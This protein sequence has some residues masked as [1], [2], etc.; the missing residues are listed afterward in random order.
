MSRIYV[1]AVSSNS[2]WPDSFRKEF[3]GQI[4]K[5][6]AILTES[7]H[8]IHGNTVLYV[9]RDDLTDL[10]ACVK[11][12]ELV[13][14]L[15][16]NLIHWTRQI[17]EVIAGSDASHSDAQHEDRG[18]LAEIQHWKSRSDDLS[19]I[20]SQLE[21]SDVKRICSVLEKA[22]SSYLKPFSDLAQEIMDGSEEAR[23]NLKFLQILFDPCT[24]LA[25]AKPKDISQHLPEILNLIRVIWSLSKYYHTPERIM[26]LL[27]KVSNEIILRCCENINLKDIFDGKIEE[28]SQVLQESI[29]SGDDWKEIY[30]KMVE[31]MK[32][33][34]PE[35]AWNYDE[36]RIFAQIDAFMQRCRD[37]LEVCESQNQFSPSEESEIP[38]FSGV[39][40]DEI[41]KNLTKIQQSFKKLIT[42]FSNL[43]YNILDVKATKW[44]DD[45]NV[46]KSGVKDLEMMM[47]NVITS[48]FET[49]STVEQGL[50]M[51]EAFHHMAK[52]EA[53]KRTV[54]NK[55]SFVYSLF[56][57]ELTKVGREFNQNRSSPPI[58]QGIP[59]YSGSAVWAK[60][61]QK[62]LQDQMTVLN[63]TYYLRSCREHEEAQSNFYALSGAIDEYIKKNYQDWASNIDENYASKLER[64]LLVQVAGGFLEMNFDKDLIRLFQEVRYWEKLVFPIPY[65][66]MEMASQREKFR[67]IRENVLLV[68]RDFNKILSITDKGERKLFQEKLN[69]LKRIINPGITKMHWSSRGIVDYY[70]RQCRTHCEEVYR[71]VLTF[72]S[73]HDQIMKL[74]NMIADTLLVKIE[75]KRIYEEGSFE[76]VQDEHR[77][78]VKNKLKNA[79]EEIKNLISKSYEMFSNDMEEIQ[80]EW[81][82]YVSKIDRMVEDALRTTVKKSLQEISKAIN[83]DA[84]TEVHPIFKVNMT[85]ERERVEFKPT[86]NN[87]TQMV[88]NVSK[89]LITV[90]TIIPKLKDLH[91][92]KETFYSRISNDEDILKIMVS[93][94]GGMS[95]SLDKLQ[96]YLTF[97]EKYKHTWDYD[98]DA[99]I[100]RYAKANRTLATFEQDIQRYRELQND[101]LAEDTI[102]NM[103]FICIDCS[104]LK[105]AIVGHCIGWQNKFTSLLHSNATSE[106]NA[107]RDLFF[108]NTQ[109]FQ[110]HPS[111]LDELAE[112][113]SQ[114][115]KLQEETDSISARFEP[116]Y[117][118]YKLLEKFDII[119]PEEEKEQVE[120]LPNEFVK[121]KA[122]LTDSE[123][124]LHSSKEKMKGNL[125]QSLEQ[126]KIDV[127]N[128]RKKFLSEGPFDPN[129]DLQKAFSQ[130]QH[131][132][133]MTSAD[134]EGESKMQ[135]G[136]DLFG[137][138]RPVY[139]DISLVE[140]DLELLE[141]CWNLVKEWNEM[142]ELWKN[143]RFTDLHTEEMEE[144]AAKFNKKLQ[145]IGKEVKN[146]DIWEKTRE[147]VD[148]FKRALPLIQDLRNEA[149]RDRHW[150]QL[151]EHIGK[152][153]EPSD[154]DFTLNKVMELQLPSFAEVIGT[155]SNSASKELMIEKAVNNMESTWNVMKLD[156]HKYK[157]DYLMLRSTE[158]VFAALEDNVVSLST[159]KSSKYALSF[160]PELEKWEKTLSLVSETVESILTVQRY[161]M[162]LENIFVGSEDIRKQLPTESKLFDQINTTWKQI[163]KRLQQ[164]NN[165]VSACKL[166]GMLKTLNN[167]ES[168]LEKI[169]KSLDQYLETKRQAFP[170]FYF[171]SNDDLLEILGQARDPLAVQPHLKKCFEA[172]KSLKLEPPGKDGRRNY[173]AIAMNSPDG[174]SVLFTS[175]IT[176]DGPVEVWLLEIENVMRQTLR[177]VL[178]QTLSS[179]KGTKRE[180]W[181]NDFPGQLLI[182][183]GQMQWTSECEKG[184]LDSE[185]GNKVGVRTAKKKQVV[186]LNKY[187]EMVRGQLNK[188]NRNKVVAIITIEVHARDVIDKMIKNGTAYLNDFEWMSQLR[189]YWDKEIDDCLTKQNQSKFVYGYEYQGNN[190]RLVI[191]PLTD[192]CY[193]TLTT[194]LHLKRGGNPLGPAGTGKT[195]TVKDLGKAIAMYVLVFNCSDGLDYKSLG[196]MF[197]GLCQQGA[198]SCFDE[199]NR[200]DIEVLSVVAQQILQI[201]TAVKEMQNSLIF[202]G[203]HIKL[204]KTLGIFVTMNPGYA[205]RSELPDNLKALL[206]P[207]AMMVPDLALIAEIM[208]S[209]EGFQ[210]GKVL[211]KKLITLYQLMQ[212]QMSKQDHYDYGM[213]AIKAVLV[214][215][216]SVKRV[217]PEMSEEVILLRAVRDMSIPKLVGSDIH[218]FNALCGDLFPGVELPVV[219]YGDLL[220]GIK[221]SLTESKLQHN[222]NIILK[223]IQIYEAKACRH[224]NMLVGRTKTGKTTAWSTL[225][226]AHNSL[227]K[228]NKSGWERVV[229]FVLNPKAFSLG[230]LFGEYNLMTREWTDGTL[231]S[232]MREACSDEKPDNKWI[233]LDG[234]VDTLWIES[235]NTVL[236]DNKLLTLINGERIA[237][238]PMV[239]CLFEVEDLAVASPATV[240]R[241]GMIYFDLSGLGW[242][243]YTDSWL[244]SKKG[245]EEDAEMVPLISNLIDKYIDKILE[246]KKHNVTELIPLSPLNTVISLTKLF[247]ALS[248]KANGIVP[249]SDTL[250]KMTEMWFIYCLA[251]SLGAGADENGRRKLDV[252]IREI[253]AQLP[254]K[255]TV[256]DYFVDVHKVQ[257]SPWEEKVTAKQWRP[258]ADTPFFKLIVPTI[259]SIRNTSLLDVL[260]REHRDVIIT[261]PVGCGK[262]TI[263]QQCLAQL[264][265]SMTDLNIQFSA[266][267]SSNRVQETIEASVEKRTKDT[268]APPAN[269]KM[270]IFIDDM[271]MPQKDTFGSMPPLELLKMWLEYGFWYDRAKQLKRFIKDC[272]VLGALG[273]PGGGRNWLPQRFQSK[274]H[275]VNFTFPD[276][277][278]VRRIF[279][280][281]INMKLQHFADEIKPLGDIM[282]QATIEIYNTVKAELLPTPS[283][284]HYMFN[285]RDLSRVFQGVLRADEQFTDSR[286]AMTRLWIHE[287]FRLFHD[288]LTDDVDRA[289]FRKLMEGKL[290][291][292]FQTSW[293]Q[294][295]IGNGNP[296]M[297]V[298]FLRAGYDPPPYEE[299]MD[300]A[301]FKTFVEEKLDEYNTEPGVVQMNLVLFRDALAHLSRICRVIKLPR[302]NCLL[303]GVG[304]SGR[305]SISRLACYICE[306]KVFMIEISKSYRY[307]DFRED[308]KKLFEMAG[309]K[310][311]PT[312]FLFNDSQIVEEFFLEDINC[313]LGSGEVPGLFAPDEVSNYRELMRNEARAAGME[314][315]PTVLWQLFIERCRQNL[316]LILCMSPIGEAFRTRVRMFPNLVNCCTIDWFPAWSNEAL[317]EVSLKFLN[318]S[319]NQNLKEATQGVSNIFA[320]VH[321]SVIDSTAR[322]LQELKR[323]NYVTPTNFLELVK[324]YLS[325]LTQKQKE[326]EDQI[327]KFR[328]GIEKLDNS[329]EQVE[330]MSQELEVKKKEVSV[331]QKECE[332]MLVVIVR[333]RKI[334]DEQQRS[335]QAESE[336]VQREEAETQKIADDAQKDL[337]EALP[338]LSAAEEA[339]NALNKKDLS[340]I[341]AYAKPPPLVEMV[342]EAV[343][344]L[345]KGQSSWEEAKKELGNP[346]FLS[347][348][349]NYDKDANLNESMLS[350]VSKYTSKP[351]F[352]PEQVGKQSGAAK[353]LC[354][355]VRA[356]V[357]YGRVAKNVAPKKAK[358]KA[359]MDSLV[360]KRS[361][362]KAAQDD[363][364]EVTD[365][366]LALKNKYD[367][368]VGLKERLMNESAELEAKLDRAQRL[369]G[370]LGGERDRWDESATNLESKITKL[371]GDCA[372]SAAYLSYCGPF[373][374]EYR[375]DLVHNSWIPNLKKLE[376]VASDNFSFSE[377]LAEPSTVRTWNIQGLPP[378]SFSTENGVL[379]TLGRRW[380]LCIDPQF[381]ANKWIK[382]LEKSQG[383]KVM[384][385]NMS[386]WMRQM[387]N[388]IQFG[389]P[390]LLQDIGEELD[391]S[392]EPV[393]SKAVTKKGNSMILK[394][395]D[396]EVDFNPD[397]KLYITTKLSNPHYTPEISTKTTVI[398]FAV[399]EDGMEDQVLGLVV[400][401]E[402]PDLEEKNQE[403]IVN[404]AQGK[405][406]L[407]DLENKILALLSSSKGSLLDDASLVDTL[408]TSKLTAEEVSSQLQISEGTKEQIDK[409]RESYRPCATRASILYFVITDLT[410]LDTMYQ[411]SLDYYFDLYNQ[412]ID[413][414]AK[415]EDLEER[416][417]HLNTYHTASAYRNICRSLFEKHKL[418]FSFQMCVKILQKSSKINNDEYQ[419]FLRGPGLV[420]K[421]S[422]PPNPAPEWIA[423]SAW[424]AICEMDN[425]LSNL[426]NITSSLE[427]NTSDWKKWY[428]NQEPESSPLPGE[429]EN[430]CTEL[431]RLVLIRFLRPDRVIFAV[432]SFVAN[433]LGPKFVEPPAFDLDLVYND[434]LPTAPL[435]FVLSPGVDPVVMLK[436]KAEQKGIGDKFYS[437]SLGQGQGPIAGRMLDEGM[438]DGH[439]VFLA[440]CHLCLSYMGEL[441]KRVAELPSRQLHPEF[442][443]WLS[444]APTPKFPMSILQSGLKMT[445]EPPRGIKPN[446]TRLLNKFTEPQFER[447]KKLSKYKKMCFVLCYFHASLLERRKFKNLGW[448]IPYD[449]NDS[450]F[451]ICEDLL[452]LYL[453]NYEQTPWEAI[454][455]LIGE[456]NYGG[457]VTD[458]WDRRLVTTY[459]ESWYSETLF[460]TENFKL[461]SLPTYYIPEDG[462]LQSYKD[463]VAQLPN[464]DAPEAFGQHR[465]A[466]IASQIE[467]TNE[468]LEALLMLQPRVI[469]GSGASREQIV[470]GIATEL[471]EQLPH[472]MDLDAFM[473]AKM[474]D[475]SALHVVL[476]QEVERYNL[477]MRDVRGQLTELKKAIKGTVVMTSDL[478]EVF[479]CLFDGRI[480]NQWLK[481]YPSLKPLATWSRDLLDRVKQF[482][483]WGTGTYPVVYNL[484]Y[485][486]FP[487]GF[488]TAVLQNSA[489]RNSVSIDVLSWDFVIQVNEVK[490]PPREGVYIGGTFLEGAGWDA[491]ATCL[492]EPNPMELLISMP[493]INFKPTESKK[494]ASKGIYQCPCYY[495]PVRT[496]T[497]ERPSYIITV[498]LRSGKAE[499]DH[500]IKR[501]TA[502]LL[503]AAT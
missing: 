23:D 493:V 301:A 89:E 428:V 407:V 77:S 15:E 306:F 58:S 160:L 252:C 75:N 398:N 328:N 388:A 202:E 437:L 450:D 280:T 297:F 458:N 152:T 44:H 63:S 155:I 480:P 339:L 42:N 482:S 12:K 191:T 435:I 377:F 4:H 425:R 381:Q 419:F 101:I 142:W 441:E 495:Y 87:L 96:K 198:W 319:T 131:W 59:K 84:K 491:E 94:M 171:I 295:Y 401:K 418:L 332:E 240:S 426:R 172:I 197:S 193:M 475:Q 248:T 41:S 221:E 331:A 237:L 170:R 354:L 251:W 185:K 109:K 461:S 455:Y 267:T 274:F 167:L 235:M 371:I 103:N 7:S 378:D 81:H 91:D 115:K 153:F 369:V 245:K 190:G 496:G 340:E 445:T 365:K 380:P 151:M 108:S 120:S 220:Q 501:G 20:S 383:L 154:D 375:L 182:T 317:Q 409:A 218:L 438:R 1:P 266:Q 405:R 95:S 322:M 139:K 477:L 242:R 135:A 16:T 45:Y 9:P 335:I 334:V 118:H 114:C 307:N 110:T 408:Q 144:A 285:M 88:N 14:R 223:T 148:Q 320:V 264:P 287:S 224:G 343:M 348:L 308:L 281:L 78:D 486:T 137:L 349:I 215:A 494:K 427:Q 374:A 305:Q 311:Q 90:V 82:R 136:V 212:Q 11:D 436:L 421:S 434:S 503:S 362:L 379:V 366:M 161:W 177:K 338:A 373:T 49:V 257:W 402:R 390:V 299:V 71:L 111:N 312:V 278:Q 246:N 206:R 28:P 410:N 330:V 165:V 389:N 489:R 17:K 346:S 54:Q 86:M 471:L 18:P 353:S 247:D 214:V 234:P 296:T 225:Q 372:I 255:N 175:H 72:K 124:S 271:N 351:E 216:G 336:K 442:R 453:D 249:G 105:Q 48:A 147:K 83:G 263:I 392:L 265:E 250:A 468:M 485:F 112:L 352:D 21:R 479:V 416:I 473:A 140:K 181:V 73:N 447:S 370:G 282:T 60:S 211:G 399:K 196:R 5:F 459:L 484:G 236:D 189:F 231:S 164:E 188:L 169:Q 382:N 368:S 219:D 122:M 298:D 415:S 244:E 439:W 227:K 66:A 204:I 422:H 34:D 209:S 465:N 156:I 424:E 413:K 13:Q 279:G 304:G 329:R 179:M 342:M 102:V 277:S 141:Q 200:I 467:D 107:L 454:R 233:L 318:E 358:L 79:H 376:I 117:D 106:L 121:F 98:K 260:I 310:N 443:M 397:F 270:I 321:T 444:S 487:T 347:E 123:R 65:T 309:A 273:P 138:D 24:K 174:E 205:G 275:C 157:E 168:N 386:D 327:F 384:D 149:L 116:L 502:M 93:V 210:N 70:C 238:P 243:S 208:L 462:P 239:K 333:D 207:I 113:I 394:L 53:I 180:K 39:Q 30:R 133:Q 128:K 178:N 97:W 451:D 40:G 364:Q 286:D 176:I 22:K 52:R 50:R 26:G 80:R 478:D 294:I 163:M 474:D 192:R 64:N 344:V 143:G 187:A 499:A 232:C 3:S 288:R 217:D 158:E 431:Q 27:R 326:L 456:A 497:R 325:V 31:R 449:F 126:F 184:L 259:D 213:R 300:E 99:Y 186:L 195:E 183:A 323:N 199:F 10:D 440:N 25:S 228:Q 290:E 74:G 6:M 359:A 448:N 159:M 256:Y 229:T 420:D 35:K 130:I 289:W 316:H 314:E 203:I 38:V 43:K 261:G 324:V 8:Q 134:R 483:D 412:S 150:I 403:L 253:D 69:N 67:V 355:W 417:R 404:V 125:I 400:K 357:V 201:L 56:F 460:D 268:Y 76:Q 269:K 293:S 498:E 33:I 481:G 162:Y 470:D 258:T 345:R 490:E 68:V 37:L 476:F 393:L 254:G 391:S 367:E 452:V 194:A 173:E 492:Q 464:F 272:F 32:I 429:W 469:D 47:Q 2:T 500:W 51:L 127:A 92:S 472:D 292:L 313:L 85:L 341:K 411:F 363:L 262:T 457:R 432:S 241:A 46:F 230:E 276:D 387:E 62:R 61:L 132:K 104:P 129:T 396:K 100:R 222:Q 291:T 395:G 315:T 57:N 360:K 350:K 145:R 337:D 414:S 29:K 466:D 356:M 226:K 361:Q 423:E 146:W 119:I 446:L 406:T 302:G 36:S 488:L 463:Y 430:K 19:G 385:L 284:S 283:K 55:S 166:D 303:I 433:N